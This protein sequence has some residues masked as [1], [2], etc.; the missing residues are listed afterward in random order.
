M[1]NQLSKTIEVTL[2]LGIL[3]V[4]NLVTPTSSNMGQIPATI[5]YVNPNKPVDVDAAKEEFIKA[6]DANDALTQKLIKYSKSLES[7]NANLKR[8]LKERPYKYATSVKWIE[9][10]G[11]DSITEIYYTDTVFAFI[12]KS[13]ANFLAKPKYDT[14]YVAGN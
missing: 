8:Q 4:L 3:F 7:E 11:I 2:L 9:K 14:I 6:T 13:R 1:I 10:P 12:S 5:N